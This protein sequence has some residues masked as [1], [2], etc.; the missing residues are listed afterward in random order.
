MVEHKQTPA[1]IYTLD[2]AS[3]ESKKN[4]LLKAASGGGGGARL[5]PCW[6][7]GSM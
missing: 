2:Q 3:L 6:V 1:F 4:L 5:I 7:Q